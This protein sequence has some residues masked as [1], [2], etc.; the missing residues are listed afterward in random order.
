MKGKKL[1]R[2]KAYLYWGVLS[3]ILLAP[4]VGALGLR[5]W[6]NNKLEK[7]RNAGFVLISKETMMLS[8]YDYKGEELFRAPIACGMNFG[9]KE[10]VGDM[11]T[12]EGVFYISE[13]L[14]ASNWTHDFNDGNG[15]VEGAYGPY[16]CRLECPGH[17]GIGIHGT[18][19]PSSI[20]T[21]ATEGC[22]RLN[23][24]DLVKL[25]EFVYPG[26]V[27]VVTTSSNDVVRSQE[28]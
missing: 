16:F 18:H 9:N 21:R 5:S 8:L 19:D 22:I 24:D 13:I 4:Y 11:K 12:P 10:K 14:D 7:I 23:N 15:E 27:V 26:M 1:S 6:Y 25:K 20:G 17:K 28:E 2:Y 3:V